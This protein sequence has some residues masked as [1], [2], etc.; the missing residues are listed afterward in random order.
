MKKSDKKLEKAI[1]N[2]LT[3][4]CEEVLKQYIGF[5]W[6][7]HFVNFQTYPESLSVVC[8]FDNQESLQRVIDSGKCDHIKA[9]IE[10]KLISAGVKA[11]GVKK[12]IVFDSE[13][14]CHSQHQGNWNRRF[15]GLHNA[16]HV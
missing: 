6:L 7:T 16:R 1:V 3:E 10:N 15:E 13:E 14:A 8:V 12:R 4:A 11:K 9:L 5:E 2:A